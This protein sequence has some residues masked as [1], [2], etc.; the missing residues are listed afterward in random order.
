MH[1]FLLGPSGVGKTTFA[2][3]LG[4]NRDYLHIPI[5]LGD[6]GN[7]LIAEGLVDVAIQLLQGDP[8]PFASELDKRAK[9]AGKTGCVLDFWS[10]LFV[11]REGITKLAED[12]I[13]LRP[14]VCGLEFQL[15]FRGVGDAPRS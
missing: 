15:R 5:D 13:A 12:G 3:W 14:N 11:D 7:G 6:Q 9:A 10:V 1:Y 8:A 2:N 4:A